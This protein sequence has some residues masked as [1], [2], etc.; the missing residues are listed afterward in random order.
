[1]PYMNDLIILKVFSFNS[2][3]PE[4]IGV[5]TNIMIL[6]QL[7]LGDI[8]SKLDFN[9]GPFEKWQETKLYHS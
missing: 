3:H 6:C 7:E 2:F 1:M 8:L 9:G 4:N 5:D